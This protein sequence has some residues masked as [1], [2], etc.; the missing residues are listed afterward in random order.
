MRQA[1]E[2][3]TL[4]RLS[5]EPPQQEA[6]L[7]SPQ[8]Q[9]PPRQEVTIP[10]PRK[11]TPFNVSL[12]S[13]SQL[14]DSFAMSATSEAAEEAPEDPIPISDASHLLQMLQ[15]R[16]QEDIPVTRPPTKVPHTSTP[17]VDIPSLPL[18]SVLSPIDTNL[19]DTPKS[20]PRRM[21][22]KLAQFLEGRKG[23]KVKGEGRK[24]ANKRRKRYRAAV[25]DTYTCFE[26]EEVY[27]SAD[28]E[29]GNPWLGCDG[30][31]CETWAHVR[32]VG[33]A[34]R[35]W[36]RHVLRTPSC[37]LLVLCNVCV[38]VCVD[39]SMSFIAF[40]LAICNFIPFYYVYV[41]LLVM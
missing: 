38:R 7:P 4:T 32:C 23:Q 26:C 22:A 1:E 28:E 15:N 33:W 36:I 10:T 5:L 18:D 41:L 12:A 8:P 6:A 37:A 3:H 30:A 13:V 11:T 27:D 16:A 35:L 20:R 14:Q 2:G 29:D 24:A 9:T 25:E 40:K 19:P 21:S 17:N 39:I 31:G 34:T